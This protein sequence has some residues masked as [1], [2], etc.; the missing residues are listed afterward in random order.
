MIIL[1]TQQVTLKRTFLPGTY[2]GPWGPSSRH[3][4]VIH[5]YVFPQG[6]SNLT[7]AIKDPLKD[8]SSVGTETSAKHPVMSTGS[9]AFAGGHPEAQHSFWGN[10]N[11]GMLIQPNSLLI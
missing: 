2:R 11:P 3:L 4:R 1:N 5:L 6:E 7:K 10:K 8:H 9:T